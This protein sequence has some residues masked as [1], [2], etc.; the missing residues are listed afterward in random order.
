M[1]AG[2]RDGKGEEELWELA[3]LFTKLRF[4]AFGG[5]AAHI[6]MMRQPRPDPRGNGEALST[7]APFYLRYAL[8][9]LGMEVQLPIFCV[10]EPIRNGDCN[11]DKYTFHGPKKAGLGSQRSR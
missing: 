3:R 11:F 8:A 9:Q 5:P 1:S 7:P 6:A 4:I 10:L 2:S